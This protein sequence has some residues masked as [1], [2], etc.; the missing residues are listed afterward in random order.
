M[1]IL[2]AIILGAI[3]GV[4]EFL[5]ISSTAHLAL[6]PYWLG[7]K[8][9]PEVVFLFGVLVQLGTLAAVIVYFFSDLKKILTG[10]WSAAKRGKPF[11]DPDAWLGWMIVLG[12]V[13]A[14]IIGLIL[15]SAVESAFG[16]PRMIA[17]FL[18]GT[19]IILTLAD[20]ISAQ[21]ESRPLSDLSAAD[22]L[23][24]GL[25][26]AL[27]I[28]PGIS[29]SGATIA[30]GLTR[31]F[32]RTDAGRYSFLL[33]IPIMIAAGALSV[34]DIE[35]PAVLI[36]N[37]PAL[38]IAAVV[39]AVTGFLAIRWLLRYISAKPFTVF[40]LYCAV[41]GSATLVMTFFR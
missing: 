1:T 16:K 19:A 12:T 11:A 37:A 40:S 28:F 27:A 33:S 2:Q 3:Q 25:G 26:Q 15:K 38:I 36:T 35:N 41:V 4:T 23:I 31:R 20:R 17:V 21:K 30:A 24:I 34:L 7:W 9:D 29:R 13:P 10:V 8:L 39:A 14:G 5:P 18:L 6:T 32:K 22:A